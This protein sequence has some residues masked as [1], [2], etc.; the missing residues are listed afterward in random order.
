M[1]RI[2][3]INLIPDSNATNYLGFNHA[4]AMLSAVL[5]RDGHET[6]LFT[7]SSRVD[8][9]SD[10]LSDYKPHALL[11]YLTTNQFALFERKLTEEWRR[12]KAPVFV[13]GPHPM[14]CPQDV[15]EIPGVTGVCIGE[16]EQSVRLIA[17]RI[18]A[19]ESFDSIPNIWFKE[20]DKVIKNPVGHV[21]SDLDALPF[22]DRDIF[23]YRTMLQNR[24]INLMG[25]EFL[26]SR[27]CVYGCRYCINP[28]LRKINNSNPRI[29]R[30]SVDNVI[31]EVESVIK[32]Y[33][34]HGII[35]FHDDI[36]TLDVEWVEQF[37]RTFRHA[38][39]LPFWCNA[40]I[41]E[42]NEEIVANLRRGGCFRVHVGIECG[43]EQIRGRLLNKRISNREILE[44][45][46]ILKKHRMKVVTTFMIGL[47]D[48]TEDNINSSIELCRDIAPDWVL[49]SSFCP[50]PGTDLYDELVSKGKLDP[51]F[52]KTIAT[53]SFYSATVT[54]PHQHLSPEKLR[55]YF[56]NFTKLAQR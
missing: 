41:N 2:A 46:G 52:Y 23:P 5:K 1:L 37:A 7:V 26:A 43:D 39:G 53:D 18:E 50:Y 14:G 49:L 38:I 21:E 40:H 8:A 16:G 33:D 25:F 32:Q 45:V 3:L 11:I 34:Y 17:R 20:N 28:L 47:P 44:K 24:A 30:R 6:R 35:G 42:L 29:R 15:V 54:Y 22:A 4:L 31:K 55:Y 48:E 19:R 51:H 56:D 27:G 12:L 36:F 9:S 13:G 10:D